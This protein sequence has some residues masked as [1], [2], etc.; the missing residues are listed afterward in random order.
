MNDPGTNKKEDTVEKRKRSPIPLIIIIVLALLVIAVGI[1]YVLKNKDFKILSEEKEAQRIEL[2]GEL[3][4]LLVEHENVKGEY[5]TLSDSL[6]IKDSIIQANAIEIKKLLDTQWE[7]YKVKKKLDKLRNIAQGYVHQIDSLYRV[8]EI[9][10]EENI[11][12]KREIAL[13]QRKSSDLEK[14]KEDLTLKITEAAVLKAYGIT[15]YGVRLKS[16]GTEVFTEKAKRVDQVKL[17]FTVSENPLIPP[18]TKDIYVRVARPDNMILVKGKGEDYS[19]EYQGEML[20]YSMMKG[21]DYRRESE[22]LCMYWINRA[23]DLEPGKY[24]VTIFSSENEI[25]QTFFELK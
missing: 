15:A 25:G 18:G 14:D 3:D 24:I 19:F 7:Y 12:I 5:G 23:K 21:I 20:Q 1:M 16:S 10:K 11:S 17:C 4:S 13:E 6:A 22:E 8:N 2:R 9:L